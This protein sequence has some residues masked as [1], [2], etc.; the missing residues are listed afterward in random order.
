MSQLTTRIIIQDKFEY[1]ILF[2]KFNEEEILN[3]QRGIYSRFH[4]VCNK[5]M[6]SKLNSEWVVRHYLATKMILSAT[7]MLSSLDYCIDKNVRIS[8]PYLSYYSILTCCCA[9]I[10][11]LPDVKWNN[12][13][14]IQM[15]HS[16]IA[17]EIKNCIMKLK[18]V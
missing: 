16:K 13:T 11:T 12:D 17:N 7:V 15:N 8:V 5:K 4:S 2:E 9:V 10:F 14:F 6:D 18:I 1:N 3:Y